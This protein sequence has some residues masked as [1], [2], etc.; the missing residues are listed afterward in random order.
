MEIPEEDW[1][2]GD[3]GKRGLLLKSP[4]G[5]R[6]AALNWQNTVEKHLRRIGFQQGKASGSVYHHKGRGLATLVHG[7]DYVT[8]GSEEST[9]WLKMELEKQYEIKTKVVGRR[10]GLDKEVRV[11]NRVVRWTCEYVRVCTCTCEYMCVC[12]KGA[13]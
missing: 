11:L 1:E 5:T 9:S 10:S 6:D 7:D 13:V 4:Y 2:K 3:E 8:V 12:N